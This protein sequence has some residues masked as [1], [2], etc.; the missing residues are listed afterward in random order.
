KI[1][2]NN[3]KQSS[4]R[5][6]TY[7]RSLW[8]KVSWTGE[9]ASASVQRAYALLEPLTDVEDF[10][11]LLDLRLLNANAPS[12]QPSAA[13]AASSA[14]SLQAGARQERQEKMALQTIRLHLQDGNLSEAKKCFIERA[15][16]GL[17]S[18]PA[19]LSVLPEIRFKDGKTSVS[20][21]ELLFGLFS[22]L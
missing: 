6:A 22:D 21:A 14:S 18:V 17:L 5:S 9:D 20:Q 10:L 1:T 7:L 13:P 4:S 11:A 2:G 16:N 3:D 8:S 19:M 15:S 12:G